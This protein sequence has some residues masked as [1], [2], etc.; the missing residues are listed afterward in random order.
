MASLNCSK[1]HGELVAGR[2]RVKKSAWRFILNFMQSHLVPVIVFGAGDKR[3]LLRHAA[4]RSAYW[5]PK[6]QLVHVVPLP[7][8]F[9]ARARA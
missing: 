8:A 6:C 2:V 4:E 7:G 5:C 3:E 9:D 1:C